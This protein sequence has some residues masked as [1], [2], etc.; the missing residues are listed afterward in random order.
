M[1]QSRADALIRQ[2]GERFRKDP[3]ATRVV[4]GLRER[5]NEIWQGTFEL[6]QRES[7]EYRNSVDDEFTKESKAHC[8]E[9]LKTIIAIV[10]ARSDRSGADPFDFVRTHAAWRARH[11]VPLIASLHAYRLAHRTYWEITRDSLLRHGKRGEAILSLT[12]LSDFW[13]QFFD[14]VGTVLA[15]AHAVEE[16]L[17]VAQSTRSYVSL[18]DDLL[19][20]IEPRDADSQRLCTLCGIRPGAPKAIAVARPLQAGNGKHI[21]LEV[22]LRSFVR[23]IEQVLPPTIFGKLIDIRN[24]EVTAIACSDADTA[25]GLSRALRQN[26]FAR[27]AGNGH[28]AAF[29]ISLDVIEFAR[30]PQALEEARLALEFASAAEPLVHFADIDLPEFLIRRADSAAI[31]LIPEWARH[32]KSI[33]DDQS[34]ELSRTIHIFADCSF[35]VKQTAQRLGVHTNTVYFRLNRINKLTGINPRTYSGTSQLLTSL[36]LLEIHGNGRQGS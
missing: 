7:P 18:I 23:L 26:G 3:L 11:Q 12:M 22:T 31:R 6:L 34:G 28:S 9:L 13:I 30:L 36:R 17:I 27:R 5:S 21:D 19:R 10:A 16:G 24:G 1:P 14:Y 33:E 15:E 32:F 2:W 29:G 8:N 25:R 20:G 35:N 4:A